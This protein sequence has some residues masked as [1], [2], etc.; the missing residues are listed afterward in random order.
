VPR[1]EAVGRK[2]DEVLPADLSAEI[3][4]RA[5]RNVSPACTSSHAESG[6]P[7]S[8]CQ[9]VD[10][11]T[12]WKIRR[13]D[14]ASDPD[15]RHYATDPP[16]EQL[17][18]T[19]KLTSLGLLAAGVAHEVNTPLAVISNYNSI[20][21]KQLPSGDPRHQL[22]DKVVKQTSAPAKSVNNY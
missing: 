13:P 9:R 14:R 21:A 8:G 4:A 5:A 18:Q 7:E 11:A 6:R 10:R 16:E 12:G 15:G 22:I 3:S 2:L 20:L 17:V 19:E 1:H